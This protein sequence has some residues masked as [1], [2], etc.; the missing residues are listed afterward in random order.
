MPQILVVGAGIVGVCAALRL[1]DE[2]LSVVLIDKAGV[3]EAC[4]SGNSGLLSVSGITPPA[5]PGIA[6]KLAGYLA[7]A[8][9]PLSLA[10]PHF[11]SMLPWFAAMLRASRTDCYHAA[12]RVLA[13]HLAASRIELHQL[14][15]THGLRDFVRQSGTIQLFETA[16]DHEAAADVRRLRALYGIEM[17][18]LSGRELIDLEPALQPIFHSGLLMPQNA[19]TPD[20]KAFTK[21][22]G[23]A[24]KARGGTF[25]R[26]LVMR[27]EE[28]DTHARVVLADGRALSGREIVVAGGAW[29]RDLV[30]PLG[31][32]L[33]LAP[34]RGYHVVGHTE[35]VRLNR[36]L[37]WADK[38]FAIVPVPGG[39]KAAGKV[40]IA[41]VDR[42]PG[43][44]VPQRILHDLRRAVKGLDGAEISTW[45]GPRPA[46]P[47]GLAIV[48]RLPGHARIVVAAGHGHLGVSLAP[49]TGRLVAEI[50]AKRSPVVDLAPLAPNRFGSFYAKR[51]RAHV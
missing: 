50:I 10:G 42:P 49:L 45:M 3:G 30:R 48:G 34:H 12:V 19:Y 41:N 46:T 35:N 6:R 40:E 4:S 14:L 38:G 44:R 27:L 13:A 23:R 18:E 51:D 15:D 25:E 43:D 2:G 36:P 7:S 8:Y 31:V 20:P 17:I 11:L 29:T 5:Y 9:S 16:R 21:A 39:V 32:P 26:A 28:A 33:M 22:L 47:D 37:M 1:Q 24:F